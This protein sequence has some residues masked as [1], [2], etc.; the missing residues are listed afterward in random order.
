MA[1]TGEN[2][3]DKILFQLGRERGRRAFGVW[4][5]D[6]SNGVATNATEI[7]GSINTALI[8]P[9]WSPDGQW[10]VYA[11][12]PVAQEDMQVYGSS[13]GQRPD[14]A[15]LWMISAQGE[16]KVRLTAGAGVSLAPTWGSDNRMFYVSDRSGFDNVWSMDLSPAIAAAQAIAPKSHLATSPGSGV[17]S[18]PSEAPEDGAPGN[19]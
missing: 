3:A 1:A 17:D 14:A 19:R 18:D 10:I 6:V 5:I 2:A 11:E 8:N 13:V 12:V 4:T 15:S 9:T 16:G 7:A